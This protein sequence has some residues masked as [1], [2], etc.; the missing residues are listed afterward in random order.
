MVLHGTVAP[1]AEPFNS[2]FYVTCATVIPVLFLAFAVQGRSYEDLLRLALEQDQARKPGGRLRRAVRYVGVQALRYSAYIILVAGIGGEMVALAALY[3]GREGPD[4]RVLVLR[5]TALLVVAAASGP[6]ASYVKT[7]WRGIAPGED[8]SQ[9]EAPSAVP[10]P[11]AVAGEFSDECSNSPMDVRR[12][13]WWKYPEACHH[14][15]P[16]GPGRVIVSWSP[17][18]CDPAQAEPGRGHLT[19]SCRT[20][21][22]RSRWYQPRHDPATTTWQPGRAGG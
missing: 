12:H 19:V 3:Y 16:W 4:Q 11:A 21:G 6:I 18:D 15:H 5:L 7:F 17:C 9:P 13:G 22:C 8:A 2:D 20:A 1:V 10:T 14:G